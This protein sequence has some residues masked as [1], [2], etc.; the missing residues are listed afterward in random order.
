MVT[1]MK[2]LM[3]SEWKRVL[4]SFGMASLAAIVIA[5]AAFG[6]MKLL[7]DVYISTQIETI[8]KAVYTCEDELFDLRQAEV[9]TEYDQKQM[10]FLNEY[11][12]DLRYLK[13]LYSDPARNA[14]EIATQRYALNQTIIEKAKEGDGLNPQ[15][16]MAPVETLQKE[17]NEYDAYWAKGITPP[18]NPVEPNIV[19]ALATNLD[20]YTPF[21]I[22]LLLVLALFLNNTWSEDWEYRTRTLY[23]A[24]PYSKPVL[25]ASRFLTN[26]LASFGVLVISLVALS[27]ICGIC[28]GTGSELIVEVG[29]QYMNLA[30][31]AVGLVLSG[32]EWMLVYSAGLQLLSIFI[33]NTID[34]KIWA[35]SFLIVDF[36]VLQSKSTFHLGIENIW[37]PHG[38]VVSV[39]L[40]LF[41]IVLGLVSERCFVRQR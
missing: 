25:F 6:I 15:L 28:F 27:G 33:R 19:Y 26:L 8:E 1:T 12:A 39:L 18:V 14:S 5:F 17:N 7:S 36:F 3:H 30:K 9:P 34:F 2:Q 11:M 13:M 32:L 21:M 10:D 35:A 29:N 20:G 24:L 37:S 40:F 23:M 4:K 31:I 22:A 16:S 38:I 41:V